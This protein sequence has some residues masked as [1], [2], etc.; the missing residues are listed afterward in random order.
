MG[1]DGEQLTL[2]D[3]GVEKTRRDHQVRLFRYEPDGAGV[4]HLVPL[5]P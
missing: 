1:E 2:R 3:P 4:R 5:D